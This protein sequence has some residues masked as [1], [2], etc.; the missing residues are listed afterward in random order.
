[1]VTEEG[2]FN[3]YKKLGT[4]YIKM[5][6]YQCTEPENPVDENT[7]LVVQYQETVG[8]GCILRCYSI[9]T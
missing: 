8:R 3:H 2:H 5:G 6:M 9:N 7:I 1:M 4:D